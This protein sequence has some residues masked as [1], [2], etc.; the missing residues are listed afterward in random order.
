VLDAGNIAIFTSDT[1]HTVSD[2]FF[3][4]PQDGRVWRLGNGNPTTDLT[5][6]LTFS[7]SNP[8]AFLTLSP[9]EYVRLTRFGGAWYPIAGT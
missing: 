1:A 9:G 4:D 2:A 7:D 3:D 8:T 6:I 5:N